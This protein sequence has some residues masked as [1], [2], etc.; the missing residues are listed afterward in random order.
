ML[1]QKVFPPMFTHVNLMKALQNQFSASTKQHK[2]TQK[3]S[4]MKCSQTCVTLS[5]NNTLTIEASRSH[6]PEQNLL[7]FIYPFIF[8]QPLSLSLFLLLPPIPFSFAV[9]PE[10]HF[11]ILRL[12]TC[13]PLPSHPLPSSQRPSTS[14]YNSKVLQN[15]HLLPA[16][17]GSYS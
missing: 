14:V 2:Q 16:A 7:L 13:T 1:H 10:Q 8:P 9:F 4:L 6:H 12:S 17:P 11:Q 5:L 15:Y 3:T